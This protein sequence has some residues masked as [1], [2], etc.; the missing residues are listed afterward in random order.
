MSVPTVRPFIM[1]AV[2]VLYA[3]LKFVADDEVH[4]DNGVAH[5]AVR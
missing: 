2:S 1:C 5:Y 3:D 4:N